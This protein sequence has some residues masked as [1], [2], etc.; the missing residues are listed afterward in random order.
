MKRISFENDSYALLSSWGNFRLSGLLWSDRGPK[1]HTRK[2][3]QFKTS[4]IVRTELT[5]NVVY[6]VHGYKKSH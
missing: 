4:W 6:A 2:V 3:T 5:K 1:S